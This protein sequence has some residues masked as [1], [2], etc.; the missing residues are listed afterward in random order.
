MHG[1]SR[2]VEIL[3]I[4]VAVCRLSILAHLGLPRAVGYITFDSLRSRRQLQVSEHSA[5]WGLAMLD[6]ISVGRFSLQLAIL[7]VG[8]L[9]GV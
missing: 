5:S 6:E 4:V 3:V 1:G 8:L 2:S 7:D 9:T